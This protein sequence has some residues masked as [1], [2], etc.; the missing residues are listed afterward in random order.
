M[1]LNEDFDESVYI[2]QS[3]LAS[4]L[5]P[6]QGQELPPFKPEA[7]PSRTDQPYNSIGKTPNFLS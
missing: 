3:A 7:S 5:S 1:H 6:R 2:E 4:Y